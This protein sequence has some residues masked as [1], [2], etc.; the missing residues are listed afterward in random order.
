MSNSNKNLFLQKKRSLS[1][2]FKNGKN[3]IK[4]KKSPKE[5]IVKGPWSP[6]E[7]ELLKQWIDTVGPKKW[8]K[9]A[10]SIPGRSGKQ[11]REHW[12]NSL[13][14]AILKGNWTSEE[15]YLLMFFY[16]KMN[17]SW[18]RIIPIFKSRTENS[19]KN[20]FFSQLRKI[21]SR[22]IKTGKK[23]YSTK[24]GLET[25]IKYYDIGVDEAK[26]LFI[27]ESK[28]N[29]KELEE[30][31]NNIDKALKNKPKGDKFIDIEIF[32]KYKANNVDIKEDKNIDVKKNDKKNNDIDN[33]KLNKSTKKKENGKI[34]KIDENKDINN[35]IENKKNLTYQEESKT[36]EE[37]FDLVKKSSKNNIK[38]N[39]QK[40]LD[41]SKNLFEKT[42]N[43]KN[44]EEEMNKNQNISN[45]N[46]DI[47]NSNNMNN[48]TVN[49]NINNT[50]NYNINSINYNN[51]YINNLNYNMNNNNENNMSNNIQN[52]MSTNISTNN[53]VNNMFNNMNNNINNCSYMNNLKNPSLYP[54]N[55]NF[56]LNIFKIDRNN[57]SGFFSKR[58]SDLS[59]FMLNNEHEFNGN[60]Q[61]QNKTPADV[62]K[63]LS[64]HNPGNIY[65]NNTNMT[66]N[67]NNNEYMNSGCLEPNLYLNGGYINFQSGKF[68]NTMTPIM[69]RKFQFPN[70][71]LY[72]HSDSID[73][74]KGMFQNISSSQF[75]LNRLGSFTSI[76]DYSNINNDNNLFDDT[77]KKI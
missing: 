2:S 38:E 65:D 8:T 48:N 45:T 41:N 28:M 27:K 54:S 53:M 12:N 3:N 25:L 26:Q 18:K 59:E 60:N 64:V 34:N 13:N 30:F 58:S 76:K 16:N 40:L 75:G 69:D 56:N 22:F 43:N 62:L 73:I 14:T 21:A 31:I 47:N 29:E 68:S 44:V 11:C 67:I 32:R 39:E 77:N 19:I 5:I 74:G 23:E 55:N 72:R 61:N 63:L 1:S 4:K 46:N 49:Y 6:K 50:V 71:F 70:N 33:D 42:N 51:S 36:S 57:N 35:I 20:R 15:D 9:C 10:L 66:N 37:T 52:N 24:F 7:D 17:R